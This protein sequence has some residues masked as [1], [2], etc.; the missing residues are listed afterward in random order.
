MQNYEALITT[1][2]KRKL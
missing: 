1:Q 2:L